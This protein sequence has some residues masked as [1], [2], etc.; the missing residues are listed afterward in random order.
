MVP[1]CFLELWLYFPFPSFLL[2]WRHAQATGAFFSIA[3]GLR[4]GV[5]GGQGGPL[6]VKLLR[7]PREK[8]STGEDPEL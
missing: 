8:V 3:S 1:L 5:L 6:W 7:G 4:T 2:Q